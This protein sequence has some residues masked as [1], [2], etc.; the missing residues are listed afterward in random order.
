MD[1]TSTEIVHG[2]LAYYKRRGVDLT[3]LLGDPVFQSLKTK[4]K[5]QAIKE[6]AAEMYNN[7]SDGMTSTEK[8][9][10]A[11]SAGLAAA[12]A[13]PGML[14]LAMGAPSQAWA[15]ALHLRTAL[16]A[17]SVIGAS[18]AA[19]GGLKGY[20]NVSDNINARRAL[21]RE[22]YNAATQKTTE[23][24]IGVLSAGDIH[25]QQAGPRRLAVAG[26][27][28]AIDDNWSPQEMMAGK[29]PVY[30]NAMADRAKLPQY[31][32]LGNGS[33]QLLRYPV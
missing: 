4:E 6:H 27:E 30:Y 20:L 14:T 16:I 22:L 28:K 7:S 13:V 10:I 31:Q 5:I 19:L 32:D 9:T 15:P 24:A 21:R 26:M 18:T 17:G 23:S 12:L 33:R 25:N 11:T 3:H 1:L 2:L 8:K 29:F